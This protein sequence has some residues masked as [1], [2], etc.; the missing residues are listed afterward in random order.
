MRAKH[1]QT[2]SSC[3]LSSRSLPCTNSRDSSS[4]LSNGLPDARWRGR[5]RGNSQDFS[6]FQQRT[7]VNQTESQNVDVH[8]HGRPSLYSSFQSDTGNLRSAGYQLDSGDDIDQDQPRQSAPAL[9]SLIKMPRC[10]KGSSQRRMSYEHSLKNDN[11]QEEF[12]IAPLERGVATRKR[13]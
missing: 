10:F 13:G 1:S 9:S 11:L 4:A 6:A 12:V 7:G 5:V 3:V 8:V 2:C